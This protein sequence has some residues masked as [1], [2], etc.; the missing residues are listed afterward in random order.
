MQNWN[1]SDEILSNEAGTVTQ[2][3]LQAFAFKKK[4]GNKFLIPPFKATETL[5]LGWR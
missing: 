1:I 5:L 3:L 2:T 4:N